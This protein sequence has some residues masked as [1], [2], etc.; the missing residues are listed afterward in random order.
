[1]KINSLQLLGTVV[2]NYSMDSFF[3]YY[4]DIQ[5]EREKDDLKKILL[6][7]IESSIDNEFDDYDVDYDYDYEPEHIEDDYRDR[8]GFDK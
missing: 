3:E 2:D 5:I 8:Y 6:Y 4:V 7:E 1:M